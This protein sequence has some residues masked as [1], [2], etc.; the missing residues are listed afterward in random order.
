MNGLE[1][2]RE[3]AD[4]RV[5]RCATDDGDLVEVLVRLVPPG[6]LLDFPRTRAAVD[7]LEIL[8]RRGF[9]VRPGEGGWAV[10]E[11]RLRPGEGEAECLAVLGTLAHFG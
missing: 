8:S 6:P 11:K 9:E 3:T 7:A 2:V 4:L 5:S 10:C 1:V